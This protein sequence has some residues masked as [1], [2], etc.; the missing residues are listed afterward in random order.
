MEK[1]RLFI[2]LCVMTSLYFIV[3]CDAFGQIDFKKPPKVAVHITL[4][5]DTVTS[6]DSIRLTI[7]ITNTGS[8]IQQLLFD[9]PP[10]GVGGPWYTTGDV[11]DLKT[12][13]SVVQLQNRAVLSSQVYQEKD[14]KDKYYHLKQ[15]Q[16]ITSTYWL[17]SIVVC[18]AGVPLPGGDY[19]VLINYSGNSSNKAMFHVL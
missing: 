7:K 5:K 6:Q 14:L 18:G 17:T 11:I 16:S 15:G 3:P 1:F 9:K 10:G 8:K 19:E 13:Q 4:I 2:S 12:G